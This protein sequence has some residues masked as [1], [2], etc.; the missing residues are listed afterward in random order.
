MHFL[1]LRDSFEVQISITIKLSYL[2]LQ[3]FKKMDPTKFA[4]YCCYFPILS[5]WPIMAFVNLW[6]PVGKVYIDNITKV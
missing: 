5:S 3:I 4:S 2:S 6:L 1:I